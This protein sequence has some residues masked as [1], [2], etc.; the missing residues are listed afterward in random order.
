MEIHLEKVTMMIVLGVVV[1]LFRPR[2]KPPTH[3][4]PV[5]DS[6]LL[7]VSRLLRKTRV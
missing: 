5:N 7:R 6:G 1:F 2:R 4:L 3:P